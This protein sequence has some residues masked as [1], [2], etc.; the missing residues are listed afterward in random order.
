M[1][2]GPDGQ[3][4]RAG[5]LEETDIKFENDHHVRWIIDRIV[6]PLGRRCDEASPMVDARLPDGSGV[7][8]IIPPL[9]D[10]P[11]HDHLK[12]M[13]DA[14]TMRT[15]SST[16]RSRRRSATSS[17]TASRALNIMVSGAPAPGKTT[18]LTCCR[19]SSRT[20]SVS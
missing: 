4:E 15:W 6:A 1:I 7:N 14:L 3:I 18:L 8:A 10:R 13:L 16:P 9:A 2:N 19:R 20:T 5:L 12:F 17:A 11:G